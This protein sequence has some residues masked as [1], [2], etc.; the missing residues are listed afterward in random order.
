MKAISRPHIFEVVNECR[1][2]L[3]L[4]FREYSIVTRSF[5]RKSDYFRHFCTLKHR[6]GLALLKFSE[7]EGRTGRKRSEKSWWLS[8]TYMPLQLELEIDEG[9]SSLMAYRETLC[10]LLKEV[11]ENLDR[12]LNELDRRGVQVFGS[13]GRIARD[14]VRHEVFNFLQSDNRKP[15]TKR[16]WEINGGL[17][18]HSGGRV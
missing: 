17:K 10:R 18:I 14:T 7:A 5:D 12:S 4:L 15:L 9:A 8:E 1:H 3:C 6:V 16:P 13:T 11:Y 2:M